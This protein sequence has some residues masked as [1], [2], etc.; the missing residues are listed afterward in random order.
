MKTTTNVDPV[1]TGSESLD[2]GDLW[3]LAGEASPKAL[4]TGGE[5]IIISN[6]IAHVLT[7]SSEMILKSDPFPFNPL[8]SQT[9]VISP[10][11]KPF[12][13]CDRDVH[14]SS[15]SEESRPEHGR[16]GTP[17]VNKNIWSGGDNFSVQSDVDELEK[18]TLPFRDL[19]LMKGIRY[20]REL[21]KVVWKV[22]ALKSSRSRI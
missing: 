16:I 6:V 15:E 13:T 2:K 1:V 4:F 10:L 8:K 21:K 17:F 9:L 20:L 19:R 22:S 14:K 7:K 12:L 5:S 18:M 11:T 3:I